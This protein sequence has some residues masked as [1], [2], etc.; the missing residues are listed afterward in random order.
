[1]NGFWEWNLTVLTVLAEHR[2]AFLTAVMS[3]LTWLGSEYVMI[4][5]VCLLYLCIDK[6]LSYKLGL[7]FFASSALT[8]VLKLAFRIERPWILIEKHFPSLQ[9]RYSTVE[10][11]GAKSGA[12]GY[13]FP[14]GHT[15]SATALYGGL[16]VCMKKVRMKVVL[17]AVVAVVIFSRLYLGVHTPLDVVVSFL[18]TAVMIALGEL[19][20]ERVYADKKY[21]LA[22]SSAVAGVSLAA[23]IFSLV[24]YSTKSDE[25]DFKMV[26]DCLKLSSCGIGFAV[27]YYTERRFINFDPKAG[28]VRQKALRLIGGVGG[29][30]AIKEGIK[31]LGRAVFGEDHP[32]VDMLRYMLVTVFALCLLPMIVKKL[33]EHEKERMSKKQE[34]CPKESV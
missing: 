32:A 28:T 17:F 20:F 31:Y 15:Q 6:K 4:A 14:S 34:A 25:I 22:V 3:A 1:M 24:L 16:A 2:T 27:G 8:Q 5:V 33:H 13:S 9:D 7:I 18:L 21:D 19:F 30:F 23:V 26:S 10:M 11:L 29:V 12:T